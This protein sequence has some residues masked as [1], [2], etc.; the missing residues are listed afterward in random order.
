MAQSFNSGPHPPP[1][2]WTFADN[3]TSVY[4]TGNKE[5]IDK[6]WSFRDEGGYPQ[7][8][9]ESQFPPQKI[10]QGYL[11][12]QLSESLRFQVN[13][14]LESRA[15]LRFNY[16]PISNATTPIIRWLP[17]PENPNI[18]ESRKANYASTNIMLRNE[19]V[20]LFTG[21]DARKFKVDVSFSL[22]HILAMMPSWLILRLFEQGSEF[23][24][25]QEIAEISK[26]LTRVM[27][28]D[29]GVVQTDSGQRLSTAEAAAK[30]QER[31]ADGSE[32]PFGPMPSSD[33][34]Q[35]NSLVTFMLMSSNSQAKSM[36]PLSLFQYA[37]N[38]I[39]NSVIGTASQPI[40]GPPI[41]ELK[42]GAMYD[43]TPCII[44]DYRF[45]V[46]EEAGYDTR[47]LFPQRLKMS[48]N[49]EEFRNIHG[50]M[51]ETPLAKAGLPGWDSILDLTSP[52]VTHDAIALPDNASSDEWNERVF[53]GYDK[54]YNPQ[55]PPQ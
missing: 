45:Q 51:W 44:T 1:G 35:F 7:S 26:H 33:T 21:A 10:D 48:L 4:T 18:V 36:I 6:P 42:W 34:S 3:P 40:K 12:K 41:V 29:L 55:T 11:N 38:H 54:F 25:S 20:R 22:I 27:G 43:F 16:S 13:Q 49:L 17:F 9:D 46:I 14:A 8:L 52:A 24:V 39:R 30:M 2:G 15:G 37:L 32:G 53:T 28:E 31:A 23:Y 47:T 19:P 50:N 5:G